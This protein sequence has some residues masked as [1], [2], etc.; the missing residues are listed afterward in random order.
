[1]REGVIG[2]WMR[3]AV[4][5]DTSIKFVFP[6]VALESMVNMRVFPSGAGLL[7]HGHTVSLTIVTLKCVILQRACL[8]ASLNI[9]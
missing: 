9:G 3:G 8:N 7:T 2:I 4:G 6:D 5:R 1:M